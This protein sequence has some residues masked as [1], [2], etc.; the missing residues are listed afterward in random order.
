MRES[1]L[2]IGVTFDMSR[3]RICELTPDQVV[4][5]YALVRLVASD[6]S[7]DVWRRFARQ[8]LSRVETQVG[9]IHAVQ[10]QRG[11]IL[12]LA[13]YT[14]DASLEDVRTLTVDNLVIVGTTG[15][16]RESVLLA[17]LGATE[18][19][20]ANHGCGAIQFR[21]EASGSANLDQQ[22]RWLLQ[23][24]GHSERYVLLSKMLQTRK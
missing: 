6:L 12:G 8:R 21:L 10:D 16:Q 20:A 22:A 5:A 2:P 9:G 18:A 15:R 14:A 17:L 19:V 23:A 7:L 1:T 4:Q 13:S 24:A 11:N 3:L